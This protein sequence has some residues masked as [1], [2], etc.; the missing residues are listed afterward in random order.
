MGMLGGAGRSAEWYSRLGRPLGVFFQNHTHSPHTTEQS[1]ALVFYPKELGP[2][3]CTK[4]CA[5]G[6]MATLYLIRKCW[7][8]PRCL[9]VGKYVDKQCIQTG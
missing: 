1:H 8:Q 5:Q 6:F 2:Q 3:V 9:S 7:T 4:T